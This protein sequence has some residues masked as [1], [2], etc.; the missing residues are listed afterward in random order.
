MFHL[1]FAIPALYVIGRTIW[2]LPWVLGVKIAVAVLV[3]LASQYHLYSRMSSGSVFV[4][5]MPRSAIIFF[6]WTFSAILLLALFQILADLAMLFL[7]GDGGTMAAGLRYAIGGAALVLAAV[8][9]HGAVRVPPLHDVVVE[10]AGLPQAFEGYRV[11]QLTDLHIS[12]LFPAAWVQVVVRNTNALGADL[13]V[14]TGDVIDGTVAARARDIAPLADLRAVDG[15]FV[16]PGNHEY[17]F[18][19]PAWMRQ[20]AILG[21]TGLENSHAVIARQGARLVLAGVT[22]LS[23]A[24]TGSPVPDLAR[25]LAGA[26]E[27]APVILLDHQ[28]KNARA[29]AARGVDLQLSGHTH[30]GLVRGL[31]PVFG[32]ANGGYVSGR[33]DVQGMTLYVSNGTG[34]WPGLALRLGIPSELTRLTLTRKPD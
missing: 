20:L 16:I 23:A 4:A 6:N 1:V 9:V 18:D 13:I 24:E 2:P 31:G 19:Q 25:A 32:L 21:M 29:A 3:L 28:P 30:G 14:V 27:G 22:D 17:F 5:E 10:I 7:P 11:V 15:V 12:P 8:G 33:Y 34:L 26:P